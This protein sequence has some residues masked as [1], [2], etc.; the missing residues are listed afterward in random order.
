MDSSKRQFSGRAC[1]D[2]GTP[3]DS[4][5]LVGIECI[6]FAASVADALRLMT[7]VR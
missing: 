5:G 4:C 3:Q 6:G 1:I 2:G 7:C